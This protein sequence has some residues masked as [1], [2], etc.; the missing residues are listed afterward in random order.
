M[1]NMYVTVYESPNLLALL[2]LPWLVYFTQCVRLNIYQRNR[3]WTSIY[4]YHYIS[5]ILPQSQ[6]NHST[7]VSVFRIIVVQKQNN[8]LTCYLCGAIVK[9][10]SAQKL[11]ISA[12]DAFTNKNFQ[13]WKI[14]NSTETK[15]KSLRR[16]DMIT[17]PPPISVA[18]QSHLPLSSLTICTYLVNEKFQTR[19]RRNAATRNFRIRLLTTWSI[20]FLFF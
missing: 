16:R 1:I 3:P 18:L 6:L 12:I 15:V 11:R 7:N 13:H 9:T 8:G 2:Y 20:S 17:S 14:S 19:T 4:L 5:P 10:A